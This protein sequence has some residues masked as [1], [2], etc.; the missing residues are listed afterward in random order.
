MER[1]KQKL[2]SLIMRQYPLYSGCGSIAN[3]HFL[4]FLT[5]KEQ[6]AV[7]AKVP[8]GEVLANLDDFVG[9]SAYYTGDLDKKISWICNKLVNTGDTVIDIGAN[10]GLITTLLSKLVGE[11]GVVHSF[12]PNPKLC[13]SLIKTIKHNEM[14]NI[15]LH[16][17]ALGETKTSLKLVVP[18]ENSGEGSL[19]RRDTESENS[20]SFDVDVY[21]LDQISHQE[22]MTSVKLMKID[23]E[24]FEEDVLKGAKH[25]L[26]SI[27]PHA[28]LFELNKSTQS[29]IKEESII[30]LLHQHDYEIL[31]IPKCLIKMKLTKISP[32]LPL[33]AHGHDFIASPKGEIFKQISTLLNVSN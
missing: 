17:F 23:V 1:I 22:K 18:E 2:I 10:I 26:S 27:R 25:L 6:E 5:G 3:S 24:G 14:N 32:D 31:S 28:I 20:S 9:R 7:W 13:D 33:E 12:E 15:K 21:P 11:S 16:K 8:G 19:I 29:K 4:S 30:K